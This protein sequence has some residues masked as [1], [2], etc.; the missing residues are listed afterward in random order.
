[1]KNLG[2]LLALA[3]ALSP[4]AVT[5]AQHTPKPQKFSERVEEMRAKKEQERQKAIEDS[6]KKAEYAALPEGLFWEQSQRNYI[7]PL[8][9][10]TFKLTEF[11]NIAE[12]SYQDKRKL[13]LTAVLYTDLT[14]GEV[15]G[16]IRYKVTKY[17]DRSKW[18]YSSELE[19]YQIDDCIKALTLMKEVVKRK[20]DWEVPRVVYTNGN[21]MNLYL[22]DQ[23]EGWHLV[24][25]V[26]SAET[27]EKSVGGTNQFF[28]ANQTTTQTE[29]QR[30][31]AG[32]TIPLDKIDELIADLQKAKDILAEAKRKKTA[33]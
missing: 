13:S 15:E 31:G 14:T 6:I 7:G 18:S 32:I 9:K 25:N 28:F 17:K 21:W 1:M 8:E 27:Y 11:Y 2:I 30:D 16:V 23:G 10:G 33:K 19:D 26:W 5:L 29:T 24:L 3:L 22:D 20:S 12:H 4:A